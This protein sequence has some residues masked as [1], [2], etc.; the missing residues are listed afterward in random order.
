M[1]AAWASR[2]SAGFSQNAKASSILQIPRDLLPVFGYVGATRFFAA[3]STFQVVG[4]I[5]GLA[6]WTGIVSLDFLEPL[7]IANRLDPIEI[8]PEIDPMWHCRLKL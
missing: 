5:E 4:G 8:D 6:S 7:F 1:A 3:L 2:R